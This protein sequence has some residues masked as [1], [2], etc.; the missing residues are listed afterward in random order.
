MS[1]D[2]APTAEGPADTAAGWRFVLATDLDGTFLGGA[3][4][5]RLRLYRWIETH[6]DRV[7]LIF[8]TG[9]DPRFIEGLCTETPVPWPNYVVGDVGTTIARMQPAGPGGRVSPIAAM[10]ADIAARWADAGPRVRAALDGMAGLTLQ[11]TAFRYRVSYD[12]D[13]ASFDPRAIQVVADLGLDHL[14]SAD[15]YFDVLPRG[16]SKGPSIRRLIAHL[17]VQPGRVLVAGDTMN[18]YSMLV[19]GFPAV[20]V[21]GSEAPL[22]ARLPERDDIFRAPGLG[23]DG[24]MDA[25]AHFDLMAPPPKG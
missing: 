3:E 7:G 5:D 20:A 24:I 12:Y 25:I 9:R 2:A 15:C 11:P 14:I 16:V 17:G 23:A 1:A 19:E 6:R 8:V 18:D 13:P 4:A 22:L 10:E 21:G